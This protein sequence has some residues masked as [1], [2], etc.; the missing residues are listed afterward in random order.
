MYISIRE[1]PGQA[2]VTGTGSGPS[3]SGGSGV[4][5]G[6]TSTLSVVLIIRGGWCPQFTSVTVWSSWNSASTAVTKS[7]SPATAFTTA[8]RSV[9]M[10]A[11]DSWVNA[12]RRNAPSTVPAIWTASSPLPRTSPT[13]TRT[14]Y[15]L[16]A[17][18]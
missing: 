17:T 14:P 5:V 6:T 13:M 7:S 18:S 12:D 16:A 2:E 3:P 10:A 11:S 15:G 8:S 9:A 1:P 4:P